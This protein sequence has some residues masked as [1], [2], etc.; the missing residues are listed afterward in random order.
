LNRFFI[1]NEVNYYEWNPVIHKT[2]LSSL[3]GNTVL[4]QGYVQGKYNV[5]QK[6]S[7]HG[8]LHVMCFFLNNKYSIEPRFSL[9]FAP[10][11]LHAI[12]IGFGQ[13][14]QILPLPVYFVQKEDSFG[15]KT[16]SNKNLDFFH[17][18]HIIL[19]Y[20]WQIN[21]NLR[22]KTEC[23]YQKITGAANGNEH[24]V[25]SLLN[26]G[27][28]DDI[29]TGETFNGNGKGENYGIEITLEKFLHKGWYFLTTGSLFDSK[30]RDGNNTWRNSRFNTRYAWNVLGGK[31]FKVGKN[32]TLGFN[33]TIVNIGGQHYIPIDLEASRAANTTIYI[34]SL[35]YAGQYSSYSRVDFRIRYR[36]NHKRFSQEIAIELGN[37]FN[38]KN[39]DQMYYDKYS[40]SIKY[41]YQLPRV[42]IVFYRVEF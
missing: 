38:R 29:V 33:V 17:S 14:S 30:Y 26:F 23:Y 10:N 11:S 12:S 35:A 16:Y 39:I 31:E 2:S 37:A 24:P 1:H 22:L 5:S 6:W 20:D 32:N 28:G 25:Y 4:S 36:F 41:S 7:L 9:R 18:N 34:D 15:N 19:S 42:P 3:S 40:G 13:H 27:A 8:G 21:E